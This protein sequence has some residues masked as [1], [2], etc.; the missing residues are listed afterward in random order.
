VYALA[1]GSTA[2]VY[3][4]NRTASER[5]LRSSDIPFGF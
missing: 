3:S 4:A 5:I 1:D 2:A